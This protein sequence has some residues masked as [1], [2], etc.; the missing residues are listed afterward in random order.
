MFSMK[1][2]GYVSLVLG[3]NLVKSTP[4][5]GRSIQNQTLQLTEFAVFDLIAEDKRI[6]PVYTL[7]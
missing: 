5:K 1:L 4:G 2:I 3:F 7:A 6:V